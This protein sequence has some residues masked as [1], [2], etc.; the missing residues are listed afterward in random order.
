MVNLQEKVTLQ[1]QQMVIFKKKCGKKNKLL[2]TFENE[3]KTRMRK[4][5]HFY[6]TT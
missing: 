4:V 2:K 1:T 5:Q 3:L 6:F